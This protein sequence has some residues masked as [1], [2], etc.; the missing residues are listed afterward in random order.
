M[1][2]WNEIVDCII[3][4]IKIEYNG[5]HCPH[6][7]T[8]L[9]GR[10]AYWRI[11]TQDGQFVSKITTPV[12]TLNPKPK[13]LEKLFRAELKKRLQAIERVVETDHYGM[14]VTYEVDPYHVRSLIELVERK[15]INL[16]FKKA[17]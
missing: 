12:K 8:P 10:S 5:T 2:I 11:Y 9:Y 15:Y 13:T 17:V 6:R 14:I 7:E 16:D 4:S 3:Q 1:R